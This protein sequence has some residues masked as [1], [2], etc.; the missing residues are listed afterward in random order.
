[1]SL[2]VADIG[3]DEILL[4]FFNDDGPAGGHDLTIELFANNYTPIQTSTKAAFTA[5]AGGGYASKTLSNGS[6]TI[7]SA[8]DPSDAVYAEQ[9]WTFTGA[10]TT[11]PTIYGY[12]VYDADNTLLWAERFAVSYTPANNGDQL[13][14][15]PKFQ[16]S[17]GTPA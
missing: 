15:T 13:K 4:K 10:L 17:S 14:I 11:N 16:M 1:M 5:A 7:N 6:W 2:V 3:C 12:Y 9:V 8:N